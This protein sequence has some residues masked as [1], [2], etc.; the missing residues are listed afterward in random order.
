MYYCACTFLGDWGVGAHCCCPH[1]ETEEPQPTLCDEIPL[2]LSAQDEK[3]HQKSNHC[4]EVIFASCSLRPAS[5]GSVQTATDLASL[6][7]FPQLILG[8][9]T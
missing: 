5:Y 8:K 9:V 3:L 4:Q 6:L 7:L 2:S 1:K